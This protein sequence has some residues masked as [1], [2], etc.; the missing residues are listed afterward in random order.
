MQEGRQG[1][2]PSSGSRT[3]AS[4]TSSGVLMVGPNWKVGKKIGN[5][6]FG[7]LRLGKCGMLR[8]NS[9]VVSWSSWVVRLLS[10]CTV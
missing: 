7:E 3:A 1:S 10:M 8:Y 4:S 6:N 2:R 9:F 5:G